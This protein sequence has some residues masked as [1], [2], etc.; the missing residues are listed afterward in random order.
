M[1][2]AFFSIDIV[3]GTKFKYTE[4]ETV[5]KDAFEFFFYG[6]EAMLLGRNILDGYDQHHF[7]FWK[8]LGDCIVFRSSCLDSTTFS[9]R[10]QTFQTFLHRFSR[11]LKKSFNLEV[12]SC[13]WYVDESINLTLKLGKREDYIGPDMDVGFRLSSVTRARRCL[14]AMDS[15]VLLSE[16]D[17]ADQFEF[18]HLGWRKLKGIKSETNYPIFQVQSRLDFWDSSLVEEYRGSKGESGRGVLSPKDAKELILQ[19]KDNLDFNPKTL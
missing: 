13:I 2:Q 9:R 18:L 11:V 4:T 14:M 15:V 1:V 7:L 12:K 19:Y 6:S 3:T 17:I 10:V 16:S 8:S 5:W